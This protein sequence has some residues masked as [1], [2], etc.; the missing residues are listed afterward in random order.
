MPRLS[1][2]VAIHSHPF[3]YNIIQYNIIG[4]VSVWLNMWGLFTHIG[5]RHS[6][7]QA[8]LRRTLW[9]KVCLHGFYCWFRL[10]TF[11]RSMNQLTLASHPVEHGLLW[12]LFLV[13]YLVRLCCTGG[14]LDGFG[15]LSLRNNVGRAMSL[16]IKSK[17]QK[18]TVATLLTA[19]VKA[20]SASRTSGMHVP[21]CGYPCYILVAHSWMLNCKESAILALACFFLLPRL[22]FTDVL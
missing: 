18:R 12:F 21:P 15:S 3:I 19:S 1:M 8:I 9:H 14:Q 2:R 22:F 6:H 4:A 13:T 17:S 5:R 16:L 7:F 10:N 20:S 11:S